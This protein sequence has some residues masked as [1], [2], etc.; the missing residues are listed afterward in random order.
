[1]LSNCPECGRGMSDA[2]PACPHCGYLNQLHAVGQ[3]APAPEPKQGGEPLKPCPKCGQ[4]KWSEP[5][6]SSFVVNHAVIAAVFVGAIGYSAG[7]L[8]YSEFVGSY[9]LSTTIGPGFVGA[10][11]GAVLGACCGYTGKNKLITRTCLNCGRQQKMG[12]GMYL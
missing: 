8:I 1:M 9:R 5:Q 10:L 11:V 4:N 7:S 6:I 2:A 3:T 12:K